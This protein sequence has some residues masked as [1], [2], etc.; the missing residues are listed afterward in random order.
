MDNNSHDQAETPSQAN[1]IGWLA[2]AL[3]ALAVV[4]GAWALIAGATHGWS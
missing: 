3:F 4:T 1:F 2:M